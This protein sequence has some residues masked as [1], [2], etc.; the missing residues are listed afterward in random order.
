MLNSVQIGLIIESLDREIK[1]NKTIASSLSGNLANR[2]D[3]TLSQIETHINKIDAIEG[4]I[5]ERI[6]LIGMLQNMEVN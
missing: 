6:E 4:K 2:G 3:M 5:N 1:I